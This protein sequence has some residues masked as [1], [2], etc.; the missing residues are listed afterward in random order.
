[1]S[2]EQ[3]QKKFEGPWVCVGK[4]VCA[5]GVDLCKESVHSG[6]IQHKRFQSIVQSTVQFKKKSTVQVLKYPL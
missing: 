3:V 6:I 2:K 1:M 4:A 5:H